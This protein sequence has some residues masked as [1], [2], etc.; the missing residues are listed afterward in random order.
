M[1]MNLDACWVEA[2][3]DK[4]NERVLAA[5]LLLEVLVLREKRTRP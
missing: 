3:D 1:N 5:D 2:S 4:R